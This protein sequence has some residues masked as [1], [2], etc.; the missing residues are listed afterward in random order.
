MQVRATLSVLQALFATTGL[1]VHVTFPREGYRTLVFGRQFWDASVLRR[2][3][4]IALATNG[5]EDLRV[6]L[7]V[8]PSARGCGYPSDA[9]LTIP[10]SMSTIA[11][12]L[13]TR[14][15]AP[16]AGQAQ[17]DAA[18]RGCAASSIGGGLCRQGTFGNRR[19]PVAPSTLQ[20][21]QSRSRRVVAR[22]LGRLLQSLQGRN[23][24]QQQ[25]T[26]ASVRRGKTG[27]R[28]FAWIVEQFGHKRYST[29]TRMKWCATSWGQYDAGLQGQQLLVQCGLVYSTTR[30]AKWCNSSSQASAERGALGS[31]GLT[32]R[33]SLVHFTTYV[34][35]ERD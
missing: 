14:G 16:R 11:Y 8:N 26:T 32:P 20:P 34:M 1:V 3:L 29:N 18:R 9:N 7:I 17:Q 2:D 19:R 28:H 24:G 12:V 25:A 6:G 23:G 5:R 35:P 10:C 33:T 15:C 30:G 31:L 4:P 22:R 27:A 21:T 13:A